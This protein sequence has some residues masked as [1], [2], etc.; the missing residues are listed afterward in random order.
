M[1]AYISIYI[2]FSRETF[3]NKKSKI[4]IH[5]SHILCFQINIYYIFFL[6]CLSLTHLLLY[7]FIKNETH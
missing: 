7:P 2:I 4:E 5:N 6:F 1:Y 3:V